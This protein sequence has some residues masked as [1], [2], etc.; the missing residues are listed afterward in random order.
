M[1][2]PLN[3]IQQDTKSALLIAV[4]KRSFK[5]THAQT[6]GSGVHLLLFQ[7]LLPA[8][9]SSSVT[10]LYFAVHASKSVP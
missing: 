8:C 5:L 3:H 10:S 2:E 6:Y 1:G 4:C 9:S 7:S